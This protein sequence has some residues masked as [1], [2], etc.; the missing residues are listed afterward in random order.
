MNSIQYKATTPEDQDLGR[1]TRRN[2]K[3]LSTWDE[4]EQGVIKQLDQ[5]HDLG[6]FGKPI[7]AP[8]NVIVFR[9]HWQ[10]AIN[11]NGNSISIK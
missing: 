1:F 9:P 2:L 3:R 5:M 7:D 10:Y 8:N 11:I 6:M 4:W